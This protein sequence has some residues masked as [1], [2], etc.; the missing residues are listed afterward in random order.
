MPVKENRGKAKLEVAKTS[1]RQTVRKAPGTRMGTWED[2]RGG[3]N[4]SVKN[5]G[6]HGQAV[7]DGRQ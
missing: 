1:V 3:A 5:P 7:R 2:W 4:K 6:R